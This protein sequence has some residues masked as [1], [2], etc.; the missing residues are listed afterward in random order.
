MVDS[1]KSS[2]ATALLIGISDSANTDHW[3]EFDA[4]YR[5]MIL[6]VASRFG[7][8]PNDAADV[9]QETLTCFLNDY[10]AGKFNRGRGRLRSW[11]VSILRHRIGDWYRK[12]EARREDRG[13]SALVTMPAE[14]DIGSVWDQERRK[15]LL[16]QALVDLRRESRLTERTI[17]AFEL[18]AICER[19]A[20]EVAQQLGLSTHS[21]HVAKHNVAARLREILNRLELLFDDN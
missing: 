18:F 14:D 5:P 19:P 13:D 9:A 20:A 10:R 7:L 12:R 8:D 15:V 21:V 17:Q 3:R 1:L 16:R 6:A 11:L 2:T 4:R